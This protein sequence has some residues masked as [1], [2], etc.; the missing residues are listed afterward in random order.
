VPSGVS[1]LYHK[2]FIGRK[3]EMRE[4]KS[5]ELVAQRRA[6]RAERVRAVAARSQ[7][8]SDVHDLVFL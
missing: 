8:G 6:R 7:R 1:K 3:E 5:S 2:E 4:R